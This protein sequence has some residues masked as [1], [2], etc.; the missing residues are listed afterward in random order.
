MIIGVFL[1]AHDKTLS[2]PSC[3]SF[4]FLLLCSKKMTKV[5]YGRADCCWRCAR[6]KGHTFFERDLKRWVE[7]K[8]K[9]CPLHMRK[10][11]P[12]RRKSPCRAD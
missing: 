10:K 4:F 12:W 8:A 11:T 9:K 3:L 2:P 1:R 5:N 7:R 6:H